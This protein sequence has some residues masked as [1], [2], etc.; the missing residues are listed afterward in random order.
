MTQYDSWN[1]MLN[2]RDEIHKTYIREYNKL[3]TRWEVVHYSKWSDDL[4]VATCGYSA[5]TL[6]EV[7]RMHL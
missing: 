2:A 1:D 6:D 4:Y 5:D 7:I 3:D